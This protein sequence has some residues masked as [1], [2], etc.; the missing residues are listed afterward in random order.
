[1]FLRSFIAILP[2]LDLASAIHM[3]NVARRKN[4]GRCMGVSSSY[5]NTTTCGEAID[6]KLDHNSMW[7]SRSE[8]VGSWIKIGFSS[9]YL[10]KR[11][12]IMQHSS[13][14]EQSKDIMMAFSDGSTQ[15]FTLSQ[16]NGTS[17]KD[18]LAIWDTFDL[19][20]VLTNSVNITVLS[21]YSSY[22]NGFREVEF[23]V[24]MDSNWASWFAWSICVGTCNEGFQIRTRTCLNPFGGP[25]CEGTAEE[26]RTCNSDICSKDSIPT[27][28]SM[29][30]N[31]WTSWFEWSQC[32]GNCDDGIQI[33]TRSCLNPFGSPM[34]EGA[35]QQIRACMSTICTKGNLPSVT[36][37][38]KTNV[39]KS[40]T[41]VPI[42]IV[43][44][45]VC[46]VLL[47]FLILAVIILWTRNRKGI[48]AAYGAA[49][50]SILF[51]DDTQGMLT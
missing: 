36:A 12:R 6:G 30:D 15:M 11:T 43:L 20:P 16:N 22:N 13:A 34:C 35:A 37:M 7:M 33:R 45:S 17:W 21:V 28:T 38:Q 32:V 18:D 31:K 5:S 19:K 26:I 41:G 4:G 10:L 2:L 9:F 3:F 24:D 27:P 48:A 47:V 25:T 40:E 42:A 1:M 46:F 23:Y 14:H 29:L 49:S 8:G 50:E 51:H 44:S 39:R